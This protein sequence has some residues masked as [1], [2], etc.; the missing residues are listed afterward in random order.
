MTRATSA[1]HAI[2]AA[3][4]IATGAVC[5]AQSDEASA[6]RATGKAGEQADGYLGLVGGG[7]SDMRARV[8]AVNDRRR[9]YYADLAQKRGIPIAEVAATTGCE[10]LRTKVGV[11]QYYRLADGVWRQRGAGPVPLPSYCG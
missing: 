3:A 5:S 9:A 1:L 11:G 8:A 2:A 7:S 4:L 6:L 10:F